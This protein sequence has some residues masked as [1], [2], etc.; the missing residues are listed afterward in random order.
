VAALSS[1][2]S[3]KIMFIDA[4]NNRF[5]V[6]GICGETLFQTAQRYNVNYRGMRCRPRS[7]TCSR[8][9]QMPSTQS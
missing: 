3:V 4:D 9:K 8:T 6:D 7:I 5:P 1:R 2:R